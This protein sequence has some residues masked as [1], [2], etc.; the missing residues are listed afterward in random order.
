MNCEQLGKPK[1]LFLCGLLLV[2]V[3]IWHREHTGTTP[4]Q[5]QQGTWLSAGTEGVRALSLKAGAGYALRAWFP[6][7]L[8]LLVLGRETG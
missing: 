6:G 8:G 5:K 1:A 2:M 4:Q 3:F 7:Q